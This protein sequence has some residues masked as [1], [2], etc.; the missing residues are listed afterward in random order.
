MEMNEVPEQ[1]MSDMYE[2][3][4]LDPSAT[5]NATATGQLQ[6]A[7]NAT[8]GGTNNP[9]DPASSVGQSIEPLA[10]SQTQHTMSTNPPDQ[11]RPAYPGQS[12]P[13]P[14]DRA[15]PFEFRRP[16]QFKVFHNLKYCFSLNLMKR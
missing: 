11:Q 5:A 9:A 6:T 13:L 8:I 15:Y 1:C 3:T 2:W 10:L 14:L 12:Q 7:L 16:V 4:L